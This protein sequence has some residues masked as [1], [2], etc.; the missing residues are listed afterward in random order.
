MYTILS[1]F[2]IHKKILYKMC[3]FE[4]EKKLFIYEENQMSKSGDRV[5]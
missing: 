4:I 3:F 1:A 5:P 2:I